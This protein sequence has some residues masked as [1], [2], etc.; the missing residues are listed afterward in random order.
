MSAAVALLAT[1]WRVQWRLGIPAVI[2][3][4]AV[5]W[6]VLAATV[7]AVA[8]YLLFVEV[9]AGGV[10]IAGVLV[11][12]DRPTGVAAALAVSPARPA[13][14]GAARLAPL[15]LVTVVAAVPVLLA[16][17][18]Q[19]PLAGLG[20]VALTALLLLALGVGVAARRRTVM[21]FMTV[22]PWPLAPLM[23]VPLVVAA[24]LVSHPA[25]YV[26]PTTGAL[27]LLRGEAQ[28]PVW[29]LLGYLTLWAGA[30]VAWAAR[31]GS[32]T[33]PAAVRPGA[34]PTAVVSSF[35]RADLRNIAR[36]A[37]VW[38]I[39]ASPLLLGLV[40]RLGVPPLTGWAERTHGV[41]ATAYLPV[42]ALLAIVLHV[43]V[44]AGMVGALVVLD[45]HDDRALAAIRVSPLGVGRYL[46]YRLV[47]V[48]VVAAAGLAVAAPL[49]GQVPAAA[50]F[51]CVLAVPLAPTFTLAVLAVARSRAQGIAAVKALGVVYYAPL[52]VWW[53][54]GV[55]G[56]PFAFLPGFWIVRAWD[57]P[58]LGVLFGGV[59]CAAGWLLLLHRAALRRLSG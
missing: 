57:G 27:A 38:P 48:T 16:A 9:A 41:D 11:V 3:G 54:P 46:A 21:G 45:D 7:P 33:D 47:Q 34:R 53:L 5:P 20:A 56:W 12:M 24:G 28:H 17:R 19:Y 2:A 29:L 35:P 55:A 49:S 52:A 10:F 31:A 37:V 18:V 23:A 39:A 42:L 30:A 26:V 32:G 15:W 4:L 1:Q 14:V 13:V 40:L 59:V 25:W 22:V 8:P 51:A 36:D 6:T 58:P 44:I 43:P 50:W